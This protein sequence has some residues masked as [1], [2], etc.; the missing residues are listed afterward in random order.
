M[1]RPIIPEY[2]PQGA[3]PVAQIIKGNKETRSLNQRNG[4]GNSPETILK[5]LRM[6]AKLSSDHATK[7][8]ARNA[9][10]I[11]K[12]LPPSIPIGTAEKT[13]ILKEMG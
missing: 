13:R 7:V 8:R 2:K 9:I 11:I 12:T 5:K 6:T 1:A 4:E 3:D 10:R